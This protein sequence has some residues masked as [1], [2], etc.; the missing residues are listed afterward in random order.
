M[1]QQTMTH[2]NVIFETFTP[3]KGTENHVSQSYYRIT[4]QDSY[5]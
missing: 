2:G 5:K 1:N 3:Q 4:W